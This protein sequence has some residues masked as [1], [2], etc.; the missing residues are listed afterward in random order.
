MDPDP[1]FPNRRDAE[2]GS[3]IVRF[4]GVR[5]SIPVPGPDTAGFGGNTS[6][7]E[8]RAGGEIVILDAGTGLR[9]LGNS[10][11]EEFRG[12]PLSLTMLIT[13]THCDHTQGFPFFA[14]AY[15]ASNSI[16]IL[17][18]SEDGCG[19]QKAFARQMEP[20]YFPVGLSHMQAEIVF[21][22]LRGDSFQVGNIRVSTCR[23][24][25][26][27][28]CGAYR[29]ET[30]AGSICYIPDHEA[31]RGQ[32]PGSAAVA[33]LIHGAD[34]VILDSQYT[35]EEYAGREGWGHSSME[36]AVRIAREARARDLRL[37]HHDPSHGDDFLEQML[38]NARRIAAGS[39]MRIEAAREGETVNLAEKAR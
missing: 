2:R 22:E 27:G 10:L 24:T 18:F 7:V 36:Q 8:V 23:T 17:G 29:L 35:A 38:Q 30:K 5:G 13:H 21:E 34:L 19:L 26:P 11:V 14:P 3:A 4:W 15:E 6:C 37:F 16:R 28:C 33:Q 9:A 1:E 39:E 12:R 20:A 31:D 25:H 32:T